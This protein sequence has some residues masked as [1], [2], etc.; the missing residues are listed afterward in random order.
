MKNLITK[1]T[2]KNKLKVL[3]RDTKGGAISILLLFLLPVLLFI[4]ISRSEET[5]ILRATNV[6]LENAVEE[7]A[8]YGAMMIDPETQAKGEPLIAYN[9]AIPMLEEQLK[10]S[11]GLDKNFKGNDTTSLDNVEYQTIIYNGI[12]GITGYEYGEHFNKYYEE[13]EVAYMAEFSSDGSS[14]I[15]EKDDYNVEFI[16]KTF[17]ISDKYGITE[18]ETNDSIIVT[19]DAPGVLLHV[20]ATVNP[21]I[22]NQKDDDKGVVARWAYAKIVKR[23]EEEENTD[24]G[25][26]NE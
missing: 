7:A 8:R 15:I 22:V 3:I 25:D 12:S 5:R 10:V 2:I 4:F 24:R 9:K 16:P 20:K 17:Y 21:V 6:T 23:D 18:F 26:N 13:N 14:N 19:M 1:K 11:L